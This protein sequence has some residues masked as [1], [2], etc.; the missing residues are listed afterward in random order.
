MGGG[1]RLLARGALAGA[2]H[3][4]G[5][6]ARAR[7]FRHAGVG[8]GASF[9]VRPDVRGDR[10]A[11]IDPAR[12]TRRQ[13]SWLARMERLRGTLNRTLTLGLFGFEAHLALY[14]PGT[15]YATHLDRFREAAHRC[16]STLLYLNE[17]W[18]PEDGGALRLHLEAADRAPWHDVAPVGGTLACFLSGDFAHQV[19]PATRERWSVVGWFAVR[20]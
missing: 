9:R 2:R 12:A 11:W 17:D 14:P 19:L 8:R 20:P 5:P 3:G 6:H 10:V 7:G 13:A 16:V 18:R 4:G 1:A 15:F